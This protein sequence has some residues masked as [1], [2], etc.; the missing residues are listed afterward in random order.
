MYNRKDVNQTAQI[1]MTTVTQAIDIGNYIT[2]FMR[3]GDTQPAALKSVMADIFG[4]KAKKPQPNSVIIKSAQYGEWHIG[5]QAWSYGSA[6]TELLKLDKLDEDI[7]IPMVLSTLGPI[8]NRCTYEVNLFWA[9]PDPN[10]KI[11]FSETTVGQRLYK[12]LANTFEYTYQDQ[13]GS[14]DMVVTINPSEPREEGFDAIVQAREDGNLSDSGTV[15]GLDIGSG[16]IE[17]ATVDSYNETSLRRSYDGKAGVNLAGVKTLANRVVNSEELQ[18]VL[19]GYPKTGLVMDAITN[20]QENKNRYIYKLDSGESFD[21][22][23]IMNRAIKLYW[24]QIQAEW[25]HAFTESAQEGA[26]EGVMLF[27]GGANIFRDLLKKSGI[28]IPE[29]PELTNVLALHR[30]HQQGVLV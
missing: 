14:Y 3:A 23:P 5:D 1:F 2:Y 28:Y 27:G 25:V 26:I 13:T 12:A 18:E 24:K 8:K 29:H 30:L 7:F 11:S 16:T 19:G 17:L 20:Y 21:F 10:R 6:A 4:A 15:L 22:T 9:L